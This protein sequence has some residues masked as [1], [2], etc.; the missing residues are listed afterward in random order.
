MGTKFYSAIGTI[1]NEAW[2]PS[3][4]KTTTYLPIGIFTLEVAQPVSASTNSILQLRR[5]F[6]KR[7]R[8]VNI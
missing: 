5:N 4:T 3:P 8:L 6:K 7:I 2:L 1:P